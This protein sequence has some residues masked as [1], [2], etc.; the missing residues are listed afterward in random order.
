MNKLNIDVSFFMSRTITVSEN[1][2]IINNNIFCDSY[3]TILNN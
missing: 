1:V 2:N 3:I